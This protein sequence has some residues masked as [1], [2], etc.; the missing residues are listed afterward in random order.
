MA[1]GNEP[2]PAESMMAF[3]GCNSFSVDVINN[4][5]GSDGFYLGAWI[6]KY[7]QNGYYLNVNATA[8]TL[9]RYV[10]GQATQIWRITP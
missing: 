4:G 2:R 6:D 8:L 7:G 9:N 1:E 3:S 5:T 10:N